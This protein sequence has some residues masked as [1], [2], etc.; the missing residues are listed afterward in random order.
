VR[1]IWELIGKLDLSGFLAAVK[2]R[3]GRAGREHTDHGC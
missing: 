3:K 2:S 1:A